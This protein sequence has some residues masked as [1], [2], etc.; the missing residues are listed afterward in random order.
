VLC[1]DPAKAQR[2]TFRFGTRLVDVTP[3]G[4]KLAVHAFGGYMYFDEYCSKFTDIQSQRLNREA[5]RT[6][7]ASTS[8]ISVVTSPSRSNSVLSQQPKL[9]EF[10]VR[11]GSPVQVMPWPLQAANTTRWPPGAVTTGGSSSA[12]SS[13]SPSSMSGTAAP[14]AAAAA[15]SPPMRV[16]ASTSTAVGT[17]SS[18]LAARGTTKS[19]PTKNVSF[20]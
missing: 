19:P 10:T 15:A 5:K 16:T 7:P 12:G 3:Q 14:H 2:H 18:A 17:P 8:I 6:G 1:T 11:S 9:V 13:R 4:E 20:S